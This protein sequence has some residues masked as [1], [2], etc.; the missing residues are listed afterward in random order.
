MSTRVAVAAAPFGQ[1]GTTVATFPTYSAAGVDA[2]GSGTAFGTAWPGT[3]SGVIIPNQGNG[4]V[5]LYWLSG[6]AGAGITQVLVGQVAGGTGA[7]LAATVEQL[8]LPATSSGWLGPWSPAT[9]NQVAPTTVTYGGLI[10]ATALTS[11]AQ[12]CVVVDF[13][14]TTNLCVRAYQNQVVSP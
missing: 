10:N 11:A 3:I 8:T 1:S 9:Y 4:Q 6:T 7:V 12:F 5:W 2:V 13:T 14:V